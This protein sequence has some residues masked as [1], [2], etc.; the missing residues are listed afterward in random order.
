M[1]A[2]KK[3]PKAKSQ[4]AAIARTTIGK[5][6]TFKDKTKKAPKADL[7]IKEGVEEWKRLSD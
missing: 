4:A 7:E 3:N 2:K 6:R 1:K 5:A